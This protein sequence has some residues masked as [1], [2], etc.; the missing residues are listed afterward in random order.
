MSDKKASKPIQMAFNWEAGVKPRGPGARGESLA[1]REPTE[2]RMFSEHV[3]EEVVERHNMPGG[4]HTSGLQGSAGPGVGGIHT[5]LME[6]FA[7]E[8]CCIPRRR[9]RIPV[10]PATRCHTMSACLSPEA[11]SRA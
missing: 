1:A 11:H 7:S 2:R 8:G 4:V 3:M 5:E 6:R 10:G 9:K